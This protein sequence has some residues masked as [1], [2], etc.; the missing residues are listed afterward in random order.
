MGDSVP[1]DFTG[2]WSCRHPLSSTC[3]DPRLPEGKRVF[4]GLSDVNLSESINRQ[5]CRNKE[6]LARGSLRTGYFF[7]ASNYCFGVNLTLC[8]KTSRLWIVL[9]F[10]I[11][12]IQVNKQWMLHKPCIDSILSR[13]LLLFRG[14]DGF[15]PSRAQRSQKIILLLSEKKTAGMVPPVKK[16]THTSVCRKAPTW[17]L[18]KCYLHRFWCHENGLSPGIKICL[19]PNQQS[20]RQHGQ[21]PLK[22]SAFLPRP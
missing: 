11:I 13:W 7:T 6:A 10:F 8:F 12:I 1:R 19:W 21:G 15:K 14:G 3:Q 20:E 18:E 5:T 17:L 4:S 22:L 9:L 16:K 2:G